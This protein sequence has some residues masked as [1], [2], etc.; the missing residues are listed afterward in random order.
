MQIIIAVLVFGVIIAVHEFGHFIVAKRCGIRVNEF[1]IG[2]G[3]AI[4]KKQ[5]GETLYALR[6][7][8]IG[9]YCAM[10]GEDAE[11]QDDRA[12]NNKPILHRIAVLVAGAAMNIIL[13]FILVVI[14]V[15]SSNTVLSSKVAAFTEGSTSAETGLQLG[16]EI[17]K[18]NNMRIFDANDIVYQLQT[19]TDAVVNMQVLRNG[20]KTN[21]SNIKFAVKPATEDSKQQI[22]I[23]F[24]VKAMEKTFGTVIQSSLKKTVSTARLIWISLTDLMRGRYGFNELSGPVGIVGAIGSAITVSQSMQDKILNVLSLASFITIN[25]GIFN[26]LPLPALDGGRILC[27]V[28]EAI[29]RKPIKPQVEQVI[30]FVGL[31]TLLLLMVIVTFN[32]VLKLF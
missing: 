21:L 1:A 27:R 14:I 29:I 20:T 25:V 22:I 8:P 12:F 3:P 26:L 31:A 2:M 5:K 17:I 30:H 18:I 4:F 15:S 19:D 32:D 7:F 13:G 24:K 23:D 6:L 10:E 9:G 16:D 28:I 11:S